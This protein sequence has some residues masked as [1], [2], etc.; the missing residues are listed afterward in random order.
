[1]DHALADLGTLQLAYWDTGGAGE[2]IVL[3]H[4]GSGSAE[5]Y[6]EQRRAFAEAGYRV[7]AYSRRGQGGSEMGGSAMGNDA[8]SFFAVDDLLA[9]MDCLGI[10]RA[11]LVGNALGG[12]VA[13]DAALWRPGRV[14]SLVL[15]CSMMGIDEP[16]YQATLKALRPPAFDALPA[17]VRELGPS[18]R[19]SDPAGTAEWQAR[20]ERAGKG[21]P[22][23][24]RSRITWPTIATLGMPALLMTG[25]AD[26]WMPPALLRQVAPRFPDSRVAIVPD[27]GHSAQ[28]EQPVVFN[29]LVLD[30]IRSCST[31]APAAGT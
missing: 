20:H 4:P 10:E 28:W 29:R 7:V 31:S 13:L 12:F 6:P 19:A 3:L 26:L 25:D 30:F 22:V 15:A 23:R 21:A 5:F 1:V 14:R 27:A 18:Y 9:L 2:A 17:T 24:L 16:D 8:A 11:H